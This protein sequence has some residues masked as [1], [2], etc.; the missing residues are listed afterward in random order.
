MQPQAPAL[1]VCIN[2]A[3]V[4]I[5]WNAHCALKEGGQKLKR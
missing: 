5:P 3:Q 1:V 4:C 2:R